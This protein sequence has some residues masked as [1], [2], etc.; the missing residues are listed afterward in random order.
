MEFGLFSVGGRSNAQIT[1]QHP[2]QLFERR[3]IFKLWK[4]YL[5]HFERQN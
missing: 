4:K 5:L 1:Y 3:K 2:W